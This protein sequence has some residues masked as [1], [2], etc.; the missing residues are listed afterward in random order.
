[1][2]GRTIGLM[3]MCN[4]MLMK[5][6]SLKQKVLVLTI[7]QPSKTICA[8]WQYGFLVLIVGFVMPSRSKSRSA[9]RSRSLSKSRSRSPIRYRRD[10]SA[11]R[12]P[13]RYRRDSR[14]SPSRSRDF[15]SYRSRSR[16]G[17]YR[18]RGDY[19][20]NPSF[21]RDW[22]RDRDHYGRSSHR[23]RSRSPVRR[24][25]RSHSHSPRGRR[26]RSATPPRYRRDERRGAGRGSRR[27]RSRDL[28][29]SPSRSSRSLSESIHGED[30]SP[31][32]KSKDSRR[33]ESLSPEPKTGKRALSSSPAQ[34]DQEKLDLEDRGGSKQGNGT[35]KL[36]LEHKGRTALSMSPRSLSVSLSPRQRSPEKQ[37]EVDDDKLGMSAAN[38]IAQEAGS[39]K[40]EGVTI[41]EKA[42]SNS[43]LSTWATEARVSP[44]EGIHEENAGGVRMKEKGKEFV[45]RQGWQLRKESSGKGGDYFDDDSGEDKELDDWRDDMKAHEREKVKRKETKRES[46]KIEDKKSTAGQTPSIQDQ[47]RPAATLHGQT[48]KSSGKGNEVGSTVSVDLV[49]GFGVGMKRNIDAGGKELKKKLDLIKLK[50]VD[51]DLSDEDPTIEEKIEKGVAEVGK[52][53]QKVL[54]DADGSTGDATK[55]KTTGSTEDSEV[56]REVNVVF[57][58]PK[59]PHD[60]GAVLKHTGRL[61]KSEDSTKELIRKS[62]KSSRDRED[63]KEIGALQLELDDEDVLASYKRKEKSRSRERSKRHED[64]V[65]RDRRKDRHRKHR[66]KHRLVLALNCGV[67]V[68]AIKV[69]CL[70]LCEQHS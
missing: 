56:E 13:I 68:M 42:I 3:D 24:R 40:T 49:G 46:V 14:L 22:D 57:E 32:R 4:T 66:R 51:R 10:R 36:S 45:A 11:S 26:E 25:S 47:E 28:K 1:M 58:G 44:P 35:A 60:E 8:V 5:L 16:R 52:R 18:G 6:Q 39:R 54:C 67:C 31:R 53:D 48:I 27:S 41:S 43:T 69:V 63:D 55:E 33:G 65:D 20:W 12:S 62:F 9:S 37:S 29:P 50:E 7:L 17:Y 64:D 23:S 38:N 70:A 19:P 59:L 15:Y 30:V 61:G 2:H 21:R 34:G